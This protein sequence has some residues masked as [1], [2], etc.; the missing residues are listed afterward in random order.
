MKRQVWGL[1]VLG[2]AIVATIAAGPAQAQ[3]TGQEQIRVSCDDRDDREGNLI[4]VRI[5]NGEAGATLTVRITG[6]DGYE[7]D[8]IVTVNDRGRAKLKVRVDDDDVDD[9]D[10]TVTVLEC[11]VSRDVECDD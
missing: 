4:R 10:Y 8:F 2:A 11:G 6:D 3:C 9:D 7:E 1:G 5:K